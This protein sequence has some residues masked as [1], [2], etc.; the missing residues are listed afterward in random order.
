MKQKQQNIYARARAASGLSQEAA[1][2]ALE[3]STRSVADYEAGRVVP[4]L[5][6][7]RA[8]MEAYSTPWLAYSYIFEV[9]QP[10]GVLPPVQIAELPTAT[11]QLVNRVLR[12]ADGYRSLL[13]IAED[14][15]I[16]EQERPEFDALM[17]QL[18]E[19]I[20]SAYQLK[21]SDSAKKERPDAGTSKRSGVSHGERKL[22]RTI[23][24]GSPELSRGN[25]RK[26][27]AR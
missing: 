7:V 16:D 12:F 26:A 19:I 1:A 14:G 3:L 6:T 23:I 11:V 8:M 21:L 18:D 2:E 25:L 22:T 15:V 9:T 4:T 13:E 10:L 17:A 24:T 27:V 5:G 20:R